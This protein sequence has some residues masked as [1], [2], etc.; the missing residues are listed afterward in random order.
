[1]A[2]AIFHYLLAGDFFSNYEKYSSFIDMVRD[3]KILAKYE[4]L[5]DH[6]KND[7]PE[8]ECGEKFEE[9]FGEMTHEIIFDKSI[10]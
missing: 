6:P 8:D 10:M 4:A 5:I 9:M 2:Y 1:M 7:R 3:Q